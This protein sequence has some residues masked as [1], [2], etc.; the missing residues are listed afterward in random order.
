MST[1]PVCGAH[2]TKNEE[3]DRGAD[4]ETITPG[5]ERILLPEWSNRDNGV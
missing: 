1:S 4:S 3:W 2:V 5:V